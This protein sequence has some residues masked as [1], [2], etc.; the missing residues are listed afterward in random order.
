MS[1]KQQSNKTVGEIKTLV[2]L[3]LAIFAL[4]FFVLLRFPLNNS[5]FG[6]IDIWFYVW[7]MNDFYNQHFGNAPFGQI[8]YP[9]DKLSNIMESPWG[10]GLIYSP[11]KFFIKNDIWTFYL[12]SCTVLSLNGVSFYLFL[13]SFQLHRWVA[14]AMAFMFAANNFALA[15]VENFNAFVLFPGLTAAFCFRNAIISN[16]R[17]SFLWLIMSAVLSGIQ[18]YFSMYFFVFQ[19]IIIGVMILFYW[20]QLPAFKNL[21]AWAVV[22]LLMMLPFVTHHQGLPEYLNKYGLMQS[23]SFSNEMHSINVP[24]DFV[25]VDPGNLIYP[26]MNDIINPWRYAARSGFFGF[27][28]YLLFAIAVVFFWKRKEKKLLFFALSIIFIAVAISTGPNL[29]T[30]LYKIKTPIGWVN[31]WFHNTNAF[32]HFFRAHLVTIAGV[33]FLIALFL[34]QILVEKPQRG[35]VIVVFFTLFFLV[36]NIPVN[37]ELFPSKQFL[38]PNNELS[39]ALYQVPKESDLFF[40]PSCHIILDEKIVAQPINQINREFIYATWKNYLPYNIFNGLLS[41]VTDEA[42][43]NSYYTCSLDSLKLN[44]LIS[45]NN[46]DYFIIC[47]NFI[48]KEER[49]VLLPI[50]KAQTTLVAE[51][52][53]F[54]VF[55]VNN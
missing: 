41:Y 12:L 3:F 31:E 14:V 43:E 18:L 40:L 15:N 23:A 11:I 33:L 5:L 27:S 25:R 34:N 48:S 10:I 28:S 50:L 9:S 39:E 52:K 44:S 21:G 26:A 24:L 46:I 16:G 36:E 20:K 19:F 35:K 42:Y 4:F 17:N 30:S 37:G 32:R 22:I 45:V 55:G 7:Q 13:K 54:A 38:K 2:L 53:D 6:N 51:N 49:E 47:Y 1:N 29:T 8:L